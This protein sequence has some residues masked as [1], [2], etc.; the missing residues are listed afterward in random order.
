MFSQKLEINYG[1][2]NNLNFTTCEVEKDNLWLV[3]VQN[4]TLPSPLVP[5]FVGLLEACV[6]EL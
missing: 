2:I 4:A 1:R 6:L 5:S 3:L